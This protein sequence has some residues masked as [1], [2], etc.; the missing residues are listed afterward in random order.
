MTDKQDLIIRRCDEIAQEEHGVADFYMLP[1]DTREKVCM[2]A[3]EDVAEM[4]MVEAEHA[5]DVR[6]NR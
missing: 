5:G 3:G 2:K 4:L 6:E 1:T